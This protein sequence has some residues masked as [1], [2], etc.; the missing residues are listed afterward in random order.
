MT[1]AFI[2]IAIFIVAVL[3][4]GLFAGYETGFVSADRIRVRFLS[5]EEDNARATTLLEHLSQPERMLTTVLVGT[6]M[7]LIAGTLAITEQLQS[8]W[9]AT[10]IAT[11][12]FLIFAEIIPKS[13]FRRHPNRLSLMFYPVIRFFDVILAPL[14]WPTMMCSRG[15]LRLSGATQRSINPVMSTE[16][17]FRNLVDESAARGSIEREEQE[18]IHSVMDLANIRTK[19]IMVPRIDMETVPDTMTREELVAIFDETHRTRLPVFH[20]T[21]DEIF[22][23]INVY[24][25]LLDAT[26]E[27][28]DIVRFAKPVL[29]VHDTR[30][31]DDLL[32]ELKESGQHMAIVTDEYGGTDGL[33][34]LEDILEEI[35]GEIHDEHDD[36][37]D[38]IQQ[39]GPHAFVV[40]AR[41]SLEDLSDAI[42]IPV[43]D[44]EVETIGGY[45]MH[46]AGRIPGQGEK[47]KHGGFRITVLEGMSNQ[48]IKIRL[49]VLP[50]A[51]PAPPP[52]TLS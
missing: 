36:E 13:V 19:E 51:R 20:E 41:M 8:E 21:V 10:A 31:T 5:E 35:F 42:G 3:L 48:I 7:A 27:N 25:V 45:V 11:P 18:M 16:E 29:H 49:E 22:G 38:M 23:V 6:N 46:A 37:R 52:E 9:L 43:E 4:N 26:P 44:D 50:A 33:I 12:M 2:A 39:V 32:K 17:D 1:A 34:T 15:L 24:D 28:P 14:I 40:D 47:V 30:P